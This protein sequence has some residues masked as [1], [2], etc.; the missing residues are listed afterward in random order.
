MKEKTVEERALEIACR[1]LAEAGSCTH[2]PGYICDKEFSKPGVCERCLKA[3]LL[4]RAR[5]EAKCNT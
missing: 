1:W 5:K 3:H 4:R 2:Y